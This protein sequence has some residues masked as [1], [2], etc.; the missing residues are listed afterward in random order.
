MEANNVQ[1][2]FSLQEPITLEQFT[3]IIQTMPPAEIAKLPLETLPSHIPSD[4]ADHAPP[5][6][7]GA[8]EDLLLSLNSFYLK[9]RL[10]DVE[11]Y[12]EEV[13]GAMDKAKTLVDAL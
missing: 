1:T 11:N 2:T 12:G 6:V 5:G 13:A 8:V 4:I 10:A 9:K 7:R 3:E